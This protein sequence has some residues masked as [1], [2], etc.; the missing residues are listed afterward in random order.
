MTTEPIWVVAGALRGSEER[1]LMHCRPKEKA[2]GGLWE[3]PG[4]KVEPT[5]IPV[6]A[7]IRELHE[8]L[9][10]VV[11]VSACEPVGFAEERRQNGQRPIV[12]LLYTIADWI[13]EVRALEGGSVEWF[14]AD[15]ISNLEKPPLDER[16][17]AQLFER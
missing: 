12:I 2:H 14:L 7:L 8:E 3:F 4:G 1:W 13:G 15:Q 16:L 17:A 11:E 6:E 9:G 5:E 10:I